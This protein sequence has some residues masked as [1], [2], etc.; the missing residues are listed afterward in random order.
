MIRRCN[1]GRYSGYEK[2]YV[3][4][5]WLKGRNVIAYELNDESD[6]SVGSVTTSQL[7]DMI[8]AGEI[9]NCKLQKIGG[10]YKIRG[11]WED[12]RRLP[13]KDIKE[14]ADLYVLDDFTPE[15]KQFYVPESETESAYW[16]CM[17]NLASDIYTL[18]EFPEEN[19]ARI[20]RLKKAYYELNKFFRVF[21]GRGF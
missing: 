16:N 20:K 21:F 8:I 11:H 12:L 4:S 14:I 15:E 6:R 2:Y 5:K 9:S 18:E 1:G 17:A 13:N 19:K 7:I 3:A 10:E